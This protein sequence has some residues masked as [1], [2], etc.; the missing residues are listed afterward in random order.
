MIDWDNLYTHL[1]SLD[2]TD[3]GLYS[4]EPLTG[5]VSSD[6][7]LLKTGSKKFVVK[8]ALPQLK[9]EDEWKADV[10]RN[11]AEQDFIHWVS[12]SSP[13]TVAKILY[14]DRQVPFFVMEYLGPPLQNWKDQL[15]AGDFNMSY[16]KRASLMLSQIYV[17]SKDNDDLANQF[18]NHELFYELRIEP[19]LVTTGQRNPVLKVFFDREVVRLGETRR[20]MVHGDFS[21][22][23]ILVSKERTVL[24]DHEVAC[25][26]DP[27]FDIAFFLNHLVLKSILHFENK[28]HFQL[29]LAAWKL[30]FPYVPE[31]D[32]DLELRVVRL[33]LMLM[34]A[35]VDGK[36]PVEYLEERDRDF[37]REFV[38][39]YLPK[40]PTIDFPTLINNLQKELTDYEYKEN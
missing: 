39:R 36:S 33:L 21:P 19:Y 29:P 32:H 2:L 40:H 37:I 7:W 27:A 16:V 22:K 23:N 11:L 18:A 6:I 4:Y 17:R 8:Q 1:Q 28:K 14:A 25:Y 10:S 13:G 31:G 35:R 34:L 5:G 20:A 24:L 38:H 15:L 9:V 12:E 26:G 30:Y 3:D